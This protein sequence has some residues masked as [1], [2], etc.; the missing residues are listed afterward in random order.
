MKLRATKRY[1]DITFTHRAH[2]HSGLC[3]HIHGHSASF[4]ITFTAIKSDEC[5]FAV[6][7]GDLGWIKDCLD[8]IFDH[9]LILSSKDPFAKPLE[10]MMTEHDLAEVLIVEDT[11]CEGM[12]KYVYHRLKELIPVN[13]KGS[14]ARDVKIESVKM[15]ESSKNSS[16]FNPSL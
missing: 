7:F 5:G 12:A 13:I 3:R 10:K 14:A 16:E 11:S 9:K 2:K 6:D 1:D 15:W 4:E 8:D